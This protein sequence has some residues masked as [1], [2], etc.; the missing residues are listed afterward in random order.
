VD[1]CTPR[2]DF[3]ETR[4]YKLDLPFRTDHCSRLLGRTALNYMPP[5]P[6]I[7]AEGMVLKKYWSSG[8]IALSE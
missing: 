7:P 4:N 1:A 2:L 3:K 8:S 5:E 6:I